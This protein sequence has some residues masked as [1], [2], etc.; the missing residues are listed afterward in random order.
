MAKLAASEAA[1]RI[2]DRAVRIFGA[3]AAS[4]ISPSSG[5]IAKFVASGSSTGRARSSA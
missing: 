1:G 2:V 4:V 5:S 3:V